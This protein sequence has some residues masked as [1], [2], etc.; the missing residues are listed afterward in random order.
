MNKTKIICLVT[1]VILIGL[2]FCVNHEEFESARDN[3]GKK[4]VDWFTV[5]PTGKFAD[6]KKAT[7]GDI[8]EFETGR[9]NVTKPNFTTENISSMI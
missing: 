4:I 1:L 9:D 6:F 2:F 8:L 3:R 5:N 7:G